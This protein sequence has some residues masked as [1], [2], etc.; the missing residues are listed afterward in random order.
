MP[1]PNAR[2][3]VAPWRDARVAQGAHTLHLAVWCLVAASCDWVSLA[4]HALTYEQVA[5]GEAANVA[6]HDTLLYATAADDGL[7]ITALAS[8]ATLGRMLPA[9]GTQSIDDL[10][11]ADSLLFVLDAVTPGHLSVFSLEDPLHPRLV[12]QP[13]EVPVGPFSGISAADGLA[14]VSGGT[15]ALTGWAYDSVGRLHGPVATGD[16]GRGQPD[17][18]LAPGRRIAFVSAHYVGP[19]FGLDVVRIDTGTRSVVPLARLPLPGAGF[20]AGG[21]KPANFPIV[22]AMLGP[23]TVVVA[24]GG[25]VDVFALSR[26]DTAH[27]V[28]RLA[29]GGAATRLDILGDTAAVVLAT[30]APSIALID[31]SSVP[32]RVVRRVA[33]PPGTFPLGVVLAPSR[34]A[35]AIR[36]QGVLIL[37]R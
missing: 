28:T 17:V 34:I 7:T 23:D 16:V 10:A 35:V 13:R 4:T 21:A 27:L 14:V 31:F 24:H 15:S 5:R 3:A 37:D 8:G 30:P 32:A 19:R 33:L 18:L 36:H 2:F 22:A 25:G 11:I 29:V 12:G 6:L 1:V 9:V 26:D 20:T